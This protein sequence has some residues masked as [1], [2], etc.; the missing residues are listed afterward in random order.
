MK[1]FQMSGNIQIVDT[2]PRGDAFSVDDTI[3]NTNESRSDVPRNKWA[4]L[5]QL[6]LAKETVRSLEVTKL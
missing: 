6:M 1:T 3:A 5:Q 4:T 2:L